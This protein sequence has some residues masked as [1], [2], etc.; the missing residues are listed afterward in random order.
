MNYYCKAGFLTTNTIPIGGCLIV[1][2]GGTLCSMGRWTASRASIHSMPVA[3]PTLSHDNQNCLQPLPMSPKGQSRP[4]LKT[5]PIK[6]NTPTCHRIFC[7]FLYLHFSPR[8]SECV[9]TYT[10]SPDIPAMNHTHTTACRKF[11]IPASA[12]L[13]TRLISPSHL[14]VKHKTSSLLETAKPQFS[15]PQNQKRQKK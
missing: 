13:V 5:T 4:Q 6:Q 7:A 8:E 14:Y 9:C 3:A 11:T 2:D 1:C 12:E 15:P 10:L